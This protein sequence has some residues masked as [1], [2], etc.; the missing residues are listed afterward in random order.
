MSPPPLTKESLREAF[1]EL[2]RH[3]LVRGPVVTVEVEGDDVVLFDPLGVPV[4]RMAREDWEAMGA[5][6]VE[7][8]DRY[9]L[10]ADD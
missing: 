8:L 9:R 6:E 2:E 1:E 10:L 7:R 4:M 3:P 5:S